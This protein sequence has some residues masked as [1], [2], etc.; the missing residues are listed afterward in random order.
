MI[1]GTDGHPF[2]EHE[3]DLRL[4]GF[5]Y[6]DVTFEK[7][8]KRV[9]QVPDDEWIRKSKLLVRMWKMQKFD[10]GMHDFWIPWFES[11]EP[12]YQYKFKYYLDNV[13]KIGTMEN[14]R[15]DLESMLLYAGDLTPEL[16]AEIHN[17]PKRNVGVDADY[18]TYYNEETYEIVRRSTLPIIEQFDYK[19]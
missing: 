18:R 16:S 9:N 12:F 8:V 19:F 7:F 15:D 5:T 2:N 4:L 10:I 13:T 14:I 17:H 3:M 1:H 11:K 6:K